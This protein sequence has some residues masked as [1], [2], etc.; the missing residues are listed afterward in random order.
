[1]T[2]DRKLHQAKALQFRGRV[3]EAEVLYREVLREQPDTPE[4][5]EGLGVLVFQQ[6][7]AAEA[8][9]LFARGVALLPESARSH[10]N[11]GEALRATQR[12]DEA[13][14]L[15]RRATELDPTLPHAWNSLALLAYSE[16]RF[17]ESEASCREAIKHSPRLTAAYIN[18]GNAL[19]AQCRP[20][21][22]TEALRA[23]LRIEPHN[24]LTLMNLAWSLCE[25][26]DPAALAE[27]EELCR[28]AIALAPEVPTAHKILGNILRL[29]GRYDEAR[30][31]FAR[32]GGDNL[33]E[34][35]AKP[36]VA[37]AGPRA[38]EAPYVRGTAQ[39]HQGLLD[40]AAA[41]F[42]EALQ[43]NPALAAAWNGLA[44]IDAERGDL[45]ASEQACRKAI[46]LDPAQSAEAYWRLATNLK[47][48]VSDDELRA[49]EELAS[50][51]RLENDS[52]ALLSFALAAVM[53]KRGRFDRAAARLIEAHAFHSAAKAA[54]SL[55]YDPYVYTRLIDQIKKTFTAEFVSRRQG[56]GI[57]GSRP[58]FI[59]GLPRSGT[60]LAEQIIASHPEAHGA[61]ELAEVQRIFY[62]LPAIVKQP[63]LD[64]WTALDCLDPA[65][66]AAA[67]QQYLDRLSAGSR[68]GPARGRQEP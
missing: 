2:D 63:S 49:M 19:S 43:L 23:G 36:H 13:L 34:P 4:A 65:T 24:P 54:R 1:M 21:E 29:S 62:A 32:A 17:A 3:A 60:T 35:V 26:N 5:L 53:E 25:Q 56:W 67:A 14:P 55:V 40:E 27:A 41:S 68:H 57:A 58:V 22:A 64:A 59:V 51:A 37:V 20:M 38:G 12:P 28:R 10:A 11:L 31:C 9:E 6:G 47:G 42:R 45:E 50:A 16:G 39:L 30:A 33:R 18:L 8:A 48:Q 46:A 66:A 52:R 15:L 44:R 7:R 61:G